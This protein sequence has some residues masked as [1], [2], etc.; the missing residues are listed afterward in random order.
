V[1]SATELCREVSEAH[2]PHDVPVLLLED[3]DGAALERL[4]VPLAHGRRA[5]VLEDPYVHQVFDGPK[6]LVGQGCIVRKV[7]PQPL[8]RH[9]RSGLPALRSEHLPQGPVQKVRGRVIPN[10]GPAPVTI[11]LQM[12]A[13]AATG[14][15]ERHAP[16]VHDE[17]V[18]GLSGVLDRHAPV[19]ELDRPHVSD[20]AS[21]L[22]V[23]GRLLNHDLD[24]VSFNRLLDLGASPNQSDHLRAAFER[25]VAHELGL[26][27]SHD[28]A[29]ELRGGRFFGPAPGRSGALRLLRHARLE[30]LAVELET[31]AAQD[32]L[33]EIN[34][35]S[36]R[37]VEAKHDPSGQPGPA[38][39]TS[40]RD[41]LVEQREAASECA[42]ESP[43]PPLD[44]FLDERAPLDDL[45]IGLRH[46][47]DDASSDPV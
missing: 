26:A 47:L 28:G 25:L 30:A 15:A 9:Q 18:H 31:V 2:D 4:L 11:D 1:R 39:P 20:L 19:R 24:A 14:T 23:E 13:L 41:L 38:L 10:R 42:Q 21:R 7:E 32:V 34:G 44:R 12:S 35:E 43:L 40:L 5:D 22:T 27:P 36:V 17:T 29:V 37:V 45:G 33:S 3:S 46:D 6:L 16:E 8:R